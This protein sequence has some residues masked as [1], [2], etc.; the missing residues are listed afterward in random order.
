MSI[1]TKGGRALFRISSRAVL[2]SPY[3][4]NSSGALPRGDFRGM[5]YIEVL[6]PGERL[7]S[8]KGDQEEYRSPARCKDETR[9]LRGNDRA[10]GGSEKGYQVSRREGGRRFT[11]GPP[12]GAA[13]GK[14]RSPFA[15][16]GPS[17][18]C[19]TREG[20]PTKKDVP[21]GITLSVDLQVGEGADALGRETLRLGKRRSPRGAPGI[22]LTKKK[23]KK[24]RSFLD[25]KLPFSEKKRL[26][27]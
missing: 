21:L 16:K 24:D 23:E 19:P 18:K 20:G 9:R 26:A 13:V 6:A 11:S 2:L 14:D 27:W 8:A 15:E 25:E 3:R 17:K 10:G 4:G 5:T 1:K 7:L 12:G 22:H